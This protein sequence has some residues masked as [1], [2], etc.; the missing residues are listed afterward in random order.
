M[1]LIKHEMTCVFTLDCEYMQNSLKKLARCASG[2]LAETIGDGWKLGQLSLILFS[3]VR[4]EFELTTSRTIFH[5]FDENCLGWLKMMIYLYRQ[6]WAALGQFSV[7]KV[8]FL[9]PLRC[10]IFR[11]L[12][13]DV[14]FFFQKSIKLVFFLSQR[15]TLE[16]YTECSWLTGIS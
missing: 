3:H 9:H 2:I 15:S 7:H 16:H 13:N 11:L 1:N 12:A 6:I 14:V 4:F 8:N 5:L 10:T